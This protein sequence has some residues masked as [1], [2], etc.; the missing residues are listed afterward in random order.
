MEVKKRTIEGR[1][2]WF[3]VE[4]VSKEDP[5][6]G[7]F[8][9]TDQYYC[10]FSTRE[11][12][13]IVRG[14]VLKDDRGRA[15]LFP[16]AETALEAGIQE[17]Q[18]RFQLPPKAYAVGLPHGNK[19]REF[20]AYAKLLQQQGITL[21]DGARVENAFGRKWLHIWTDRGEAEQF[22]SR[23]RHVTGNR[24]WEVY[25]LSPP[26]P[27]AG[28]PDGRSGSIEILIGRQQD[29]A[30]YSLHPNSLKRIRQRFPQVHPRSTVFIGA[31]TQPDIDAGMES[32]YDQV[33]VLLTGLS[34]RQ[35]DE[36][37]GYRILD[38]LT[39]LALYQ[40]DTVAE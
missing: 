26:R 17:L 3:T 38:P 27:L 39:G 23:L 33:A 12:G 37:G 7:E 10:E 4:H 40:S 18:S 8:T 22:A 19:P 1:D 9:P 2:F 31:Y 20:D 6:T 25:D 15:K 30:A 11:P 35:M 5:E 14:E 32:I 36:L 29:G 21:D 28:G 24:D 16:T 34:M 13:P